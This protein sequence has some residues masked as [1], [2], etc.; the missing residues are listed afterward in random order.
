MSPGSAA[1]TPEIM[2]AVERHLAGGIFDGIIKNK[3]WAFLDGQ[4]HAATILPYVQS[5]VDGLS[6]LLKTLNDK[7]GGWLN[8]TTLL[9]NVDALQ[10]SHYVISKIRAFLG[11][12]PDPGEALVVGGA[13]AGKSVMGAAMH[14]ADVTEQ[15]VDHDPVTFVGHRIFLGFIRNRMA[16][17]LRHEAAK[18]G[19][20]ISA[21]KAKQL[22]ARISDEELINTACAHGATVVALGDGGFWNWLSS[23]GWQTILKVIAAF[24]PFLLP[25]I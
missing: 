24:I 25:L 7:T 22:V 17:E 4:L 11:L 1:V 13:F 5:C 3:L 20:P 19:K 12:L 18:A 16:A 14:T 2:S 23:G 9:D 21:S 8:L 6:S 15:A 10:I